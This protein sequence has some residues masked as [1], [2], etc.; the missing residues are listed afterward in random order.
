[1]ARQVAA[2]VGWDAHHSS[3]DARAF[4]AVAMAADPE[5]A[6]LALSMAGTAGGDDVARDIRAASI[7]RWRQAT[8]R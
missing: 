8:G 3:G 5:R 2:L 1:M 7:A 6:A 4:R